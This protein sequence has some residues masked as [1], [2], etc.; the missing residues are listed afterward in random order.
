[1]STISGIRTGL[2]TRLATITGLRTSSYIPDQ[3]NP[4]VA[5][6]MPSKITF[7]RAMHRGLDEYEFTVMVLVGRAD[8]R[9]AQTLL[10]DYCNPTGTSSIKTAVE[11]DRTLGGVVSDL[12]VTE[13]RGISPVLVGDTTYLTAEFVVSVF[14]Q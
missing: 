4:P 9:V 14:A 11:G 3:I 6:V 8:E 13:M 7:D 12:R 1:V 2:A 5:V 10:D